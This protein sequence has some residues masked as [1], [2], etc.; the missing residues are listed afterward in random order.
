MKLLTILTVLSCALISAAIPTPTASGPLLSPLL[1]VVTPK[2]KVT[3][4]PRQDSC[5]Y[6]LFGSGKH[7][8]PSHYRHHSLKSVYTHLTQNRR[9]AHSNRLR[10]RTGISDMLP[11]RCQCQSTHGRNT[12]QLPLRAR[13]PVLCEQ[14]CGYVGLFR[15]LHGW[16]HLWWGSGDDADGGKQ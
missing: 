11:G 16:H 9:H 3:I 2:P 6:C 5:T 10:L 1:P 15:L 7:A 12:R 8:T 14:R 4:A 13:S